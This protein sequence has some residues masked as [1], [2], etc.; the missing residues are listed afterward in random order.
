MCLKSCVCLHLCVYMHVCVFDCVFTE[1]PLC[2]CFKGW[3][4]VCCTVRM[5]DVFVWLVACLNACV[6]V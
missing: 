4:C 5:F 6:L 2:D 1:L 3:L